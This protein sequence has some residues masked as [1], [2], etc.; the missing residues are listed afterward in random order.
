MGSPTWPIPARSRLSSPPCHWQRPALES[1]RP[2]A[3]ARHWLLAT[4]SFL[5]RARG[6]DS[7]AGPI[8]GFKATKM[9]RI[10]PALCMTGKAKFRTLNLE[11]IATGYPLCAR[12]WR[13][14]RGHTR[15]GQ[16]GGE[17]W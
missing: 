3:Q 4:H 12:H 15:G 7:C 5:P 6:A 16:A 9:N 13:Q 10:V 14:T 17:G 8:G 1:L 11:A 2:G